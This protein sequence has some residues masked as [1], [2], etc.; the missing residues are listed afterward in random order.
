MMLAFK[1]VDKDQDGGISQDELWSNVGGPSF[2]ARWAFMIACSDRNGDGRVSPMEFSKDM[3]GCMEEKSNAAMTA[4]AN[5]S[6]SDKDS[7]GCVN[8]T[9]MGDAV[10]MLFGIN[11]ISDRPPSQATRKLTRRW[12]SCVDFNSDQ[13]LTKKEYNG[14]LDPTPEQA[15]CTGK[16]YQKYEADMDFQIMDTSND[17]RVSKQ[18]YYDWINKL[19]MEVDHQDA[20]L[21]FEKADKDKNGFIEESEFHHAGEEYEGDGPAVLFLRH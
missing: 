19:G 18:E 21:L 9:E 7:N 16:Y 5:F 11:L 2:D 8:E 15:Q 17:N 14:L 10:N 13:C 4:F 3:Y 6:K 20:D 1:L 12:M